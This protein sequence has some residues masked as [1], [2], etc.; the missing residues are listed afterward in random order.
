[1]P[2][3][4]IYKRPSE[5]GRQSFHGF[6]SNNRTKYCTGILIVKL[7]NA[8]RLIFSCVTGAVMSVV[9]SK[10]YHLTNTTFYGQSIISQH[11]CD[12]SQPIIPIFNAVKLTCTYMGLCTYM[13]P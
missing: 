1:M 11:S 3:E 13:H 2:N 4:H 5:I 10:R 7:E 8:Q 9:R 12:G 6:L